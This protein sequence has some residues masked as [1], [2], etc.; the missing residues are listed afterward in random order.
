MWMN[1]SLFAKK[2]KDTS[3][4]AFQTTLSCH[5]QNM[6]IMSLLNIRFLSHQ[7][8]HGDSMFLFSKNLFSQ[9]HIDKYAI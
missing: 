3:I 9:F 8:Q 1:D 2:K 6:K 4:V 7:N 5:F